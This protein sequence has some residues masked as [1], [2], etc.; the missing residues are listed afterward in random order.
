MSTP[1]FNEVAAVDVARRFERDAVRDVDCVDVSVD[2]NAPH[3][4]VR[5]E[6][7]NMLADGSRCHVRAFMREGAIPS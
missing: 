2:S 1:P 5:L 6:N 4:F 3:W 7:P